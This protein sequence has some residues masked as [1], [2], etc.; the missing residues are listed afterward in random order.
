MT[1]PIKP[2]DVVQKKREDMPAVVFEVFN[3][4]IARHWNG[5][6]ARVLV[7]DARAALLQRGISHEDIR[8]KNYLDVEDCYREV[9]WTVRFDAPVYY[10]GENFDAF[11]TFR[12]ARR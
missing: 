9:G 8:N 7:K 5:A 10:G 11:Y 2:S 4:L 3:E 6:E 1:E 12:K